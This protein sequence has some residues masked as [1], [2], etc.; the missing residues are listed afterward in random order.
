MIFYISI[1]IFGETV[2]G[3]LVW[4]VFRFDISHDE[5]DVFKAGW[6]GFVVGRQR[7]ARSGSCRA[8]AFN[9]FEHG[10][11]IKRLVALRGFD[12]AR[13]G[14]HGRPD[15]PF[16][17]SGVAVPVGWRNREAV[18]D[19]IGDSDRCTSADLG[20]KLFLGFR[21]GPRSTGN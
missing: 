16:K 21:A 19:N 14:V 2:C 8:S 11:E 13:A 3:R 4:L 1:L 6:Q 15:C 12:I 10:L 18:F 5:R 20:Q 7:N 17:R 9:R